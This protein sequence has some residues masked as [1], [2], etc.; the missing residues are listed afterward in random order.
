MKRLCSLL[1]I[2]FFIKIAFAQINPAERTIMEQIKSI[3]DSEKDEYREKEFFRLLNESKK[4]DFKLGIMHAGSSLMTVYSREGKNEQ[5]IDLGNELKKIVQKEKDTS[6]II[7]QIYGKNALTLF[8]LGLDDAGL[9]DLKT[10]VRYTEEISNKNKKHYFQGTYYENMTAYYSN[11]KR[12]G[13]KYK[14]SVFYFLNK[15]LEANKK[16]TEDGKGI[17][18]KKKNRAIAFI[19]IRIA[20]YYLEDP[21]VKGNLDKAEQHLKAALIVYDNKDYNI[22]QTEKTMLLNQFSWLYMEKKEYQKSIQ[23]G[24]QALELDKKSPNP[25]NKVDSYEILASDYLGLGD[26]DK[27]KFYM[28]KYTNLKDS[29]RFSEKNATDNAMKKIVK[30]V[31]KKYRQN[32]DRQWVVTG[33]LV[34]TTAMVIIIFWRRK[35]KL[36]QKKYEDLVEKLKTSKNENSL[37]TFNNESKS[38]VTIPDEITRVLLRKLEKFEASEKYLRK[39]VNLTW[40]TNYLNTNNKYLS[41]IIKVYRGKSFSSYINVLRINYII[42]KLYNEPKYRD[43]KI[44]Y[45]A[46]ES[47][48]ATYKAFVISFKNEYGVTPSYFIQKLKEKDFEEEKEFNCDIVES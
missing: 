4:I 22:E 44:T 20:I 39:E 13:L 28:D 24:N 2:I 27:A 11:S 48:F 10:A 35:N 29:I 18:K 5:V 19:S 36:H 32:S 3:K 9:K 45:L 14:D 7:S 40:L 38:S 25:Y 33:V 41:E 15:S 21:T 42:H 37:T 43:Y 16:I 23:Y 26:K 46:E 1:F 17:S 31:D 8:T 30:N 34:A 6:G 47:G 12:Y